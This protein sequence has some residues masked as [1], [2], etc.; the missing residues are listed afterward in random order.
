MFGSTKVK[1][2][3]IKTRKNTLSTFQWKTVAIVVETKHLVLYVIFAD[4]F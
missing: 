3:K 1:K 2:K 4:E